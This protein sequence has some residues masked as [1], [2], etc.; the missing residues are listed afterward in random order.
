[1]NAKA[2]I[3]KLAKRF[4]K[5]IG[6]KRDYLGIQINKLPKEVN[7]I[8]LCLDFDYET[9]QIMLKHK[10]DL[11]LTHHPFIYGTFMR[12]KNSSTEKGRLIDL[13][14]ENKAFRALTYGSAY[15]H[16]GSVSALLSDNKSTSVDISVDLM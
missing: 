8:M 2:L 3:S 10:P 14:L 9:Y 6:E 5:R 7:K 16:S 1:M 13:M 15:F 4:P 12:V 11:I